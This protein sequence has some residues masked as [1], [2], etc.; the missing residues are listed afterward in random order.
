MVAL[1]SSATGYYLLPEV[2]SASRE[3]AVMGAERA[4][5]STSEARPEG[6]LRRRETGSEWDGRIVS[7]QAIPGNGHSLW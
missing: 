5:D 4:L 7:L 2:R 6:R 1:L 3:T